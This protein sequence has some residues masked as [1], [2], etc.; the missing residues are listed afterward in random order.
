MIKALE[1]WHLPAHR[2][3]MRCRCWHSTMPSITF[4]LQEWCAD[5]L[6]TPGVLQHSVAT[7][8]R[9]TRYVREVYPY[10]ACNISRAE[11]CTPKLTLCNSALN[12]SLP[13]SSLVNFMNDDS[14][15]TIDERSIKL[16][17]YNKVSLIPGS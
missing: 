13:C 8:R 17:I 7:I 9:D 1:T 10:E 16:A 3:P 14:L 4:P 12:F 15:C 6:D 5:V 2:A 11:N